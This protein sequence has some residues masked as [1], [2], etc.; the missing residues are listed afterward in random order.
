LRALANLPKKFWIPVVFGHLNKERYSNRTSEHFTARYR[1]NN[2]AHV[3]DIA[4]HRNAFA[5]AEIAIERQMRRFPRDEIC[6][7]IAE[8]TDRVKR[9]VKN[10]HT[11]LRDPRAIVGTEF[12]SVPEFPL[13]KIV[14]VPYFAEKAE[15]PPLQ[16]ADLCAYLIMR[17]LLR[18]SD[19]QEFFEL[20]FP[21]LTWRTY[22]FREPISAECFGTGSFV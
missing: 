4:E 12:E 18:R 8:D 6:M 19:S 3:I 2:R 5:L 22:D 7:L 10:A 21:Q 16:L 17:R 15:S 13:K 20:I 9:A 14:D 1:E 11:M